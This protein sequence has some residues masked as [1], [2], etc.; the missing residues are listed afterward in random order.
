MNDF[1]MR[2]F[3]AN[4]DKYNEGELVGEWVNFPVNP[5]QMQEVLDRIGIG[6]K[7]PFGN[8]YDEI[9]ITDM[10]TNLPHVNEIITAYEN[11]EK[12]NYFAA[13][14]Q[15]LSEEEFDK[16]KA[17]LEE[18]KEIPEKGIDGLINLT[19]NLDRYDVIPAV[20]NEAGITLRPMTETERMYSYSQSSQIEGQRIFHVLD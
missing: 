15:A 19:F 3:I 4:L 7:D 16:Y 10:T 20:R 1:T 12:L 13:C 18:R 11:V 8:I 14:V 17:V 9:F 6:D 5:E 2:A